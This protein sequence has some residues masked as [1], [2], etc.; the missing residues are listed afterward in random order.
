MG[1][2][3]Y[4][5]LW[6]F[7]LFGMFLVVCIALYDFTFNDLLEDVKKEHQLVPNHL[8]AIGVI[9]GVLLSILLSWVTVISRAHKFLMK[10]F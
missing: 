2:I 6:E 1:G 5:G 7:Y 8:I 10:T 4:Q 3:D 9:L